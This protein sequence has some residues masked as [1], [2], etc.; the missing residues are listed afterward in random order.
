MPGSARRAGVFAAGFVLA[1]GL[2]AARGESVPVVIEGGADET[3]QNYAWTVT[4]RHS[5]AIVR[6]VF[7]HFRADLFQAPPG[8]KT[9][10]TN[11]ARV[12][13]K[14]L[15]GECAAWVDSPADGIAPGQSAR[16]AM[17]TTG[18]AAQQGASVG[19]G[20]VPVTFADDTVV[21]VR[22]VEVPQRIG[23]STKY[24]PL[25]G[26]ALV[27]ALG[28]AWRTLRRPKPADLPAAPDDSEGGERTW[29]QGDDRSR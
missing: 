5:S 3:G 22:D 2:T 7:P 11:L 18:R 15:P 20:T 4:N 1:A 10:C 17:R 24:M 23:A 28:V 9:H 26:L 6:V 13:G 27:F 14:E 16:F 21:P 29:P 8:W 19:R 25:I 12:G